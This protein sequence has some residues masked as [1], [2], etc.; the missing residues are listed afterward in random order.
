MSEI[1]CSVVKLMLDFVCALVAV[2]RPERGYKSRVS[3]RGLEQATEQA[4]ERLFRTA[5]SDPASRQ[6][7]LRLL[8]NKK[9]Q[10]VMRSV[11][12]FSVFLYN[13]IPASQVHFTSFRCK[14]AP[15]GVV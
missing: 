6:R 15:F 8:L 1:F 7:G 3:V 2:I 13:I 10:R 5:D 4:G 11:K 12:A 9:A 14:M